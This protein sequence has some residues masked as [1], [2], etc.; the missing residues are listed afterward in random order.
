MKVLIHSNAPW[1]QTGY[2]RQC[3]HLARQLKELGHDVAISAFYGLSGAPIAWEGMTV[4]PA[5]QANYG[6][7]V[8]PHHAANHQ[9]DVIITLMDFWKL[10]PCAGALRNFRVLA[11][12]PVDCTPLGRPDLE[13]LNATGAQPVAMSMFGARQLA[14][15]GFAP[16]Y[17]PHGVDLEVFKPPADR[18]ALRQELG[19]D[20]FFLVGI[21]AANTDAFRKA[22]PEQFQAFKIFSDLH[23]EARL[24]VHSVARSNNGFPLDQLATDIGIADKVIFSDQYPQVAGLMGD[25]AMAD[26]FGALDVLS[27]CSYAEGFGLPIAEALACGTLTVVTTGSAMMEVSGDLSSLHVIGEDWWNPIHRAWWKRPSPED[28]LFK[29]LMAWEGVNDS[30]NATVR[31]ARTYDIRKNVP[32]WRGILNDIKIPEAKDET[33]EGVALARHSEGTPE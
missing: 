25:E 5:G 29:Y 28:I 18:K 11:W 21:C 16:L 20:E 13:A 3:A 30:K 22:W 14:D 4:Y 24:M 10:M 9:A 8:L 1:T 32:R 26:W 7:D 19:I 17:V 12:M 15:A 27:A 33:A 2:G 23:D 6:T 31:H